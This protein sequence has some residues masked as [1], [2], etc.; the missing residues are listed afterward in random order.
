MPSVA[1]LFHFVELFITAPGTGNGAFTKKYMK[2]KRWKHEYVTY[3]GETYEISMTANVDDDDN[4]S[5]LLTISGPNGIYRGLNLSDGKEIAFIELFL[6][7]AEEEEGDMYFAAREVNK[8]DG[9]MA[10]LMMTAVD[11]EDVGYAMLGDYLAD[12]KGDYSGAFNAYRES[13]NYDNIY[14]ICKL[15]C[16]Y[17]EGKGCTQDLAK[18][19][20]LFEG[21][22][23]EYPEAEKYIDQ[24]GLR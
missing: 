19:K 9:E 18:A 4:V 2:N 22:M 10:F 20:E 3:S 8:Y 1:I 12:V 11:C 6:G 16:L 24:Y 7:V 13:A 17:A 15:G 23:Y 21:A 14:S 5:G